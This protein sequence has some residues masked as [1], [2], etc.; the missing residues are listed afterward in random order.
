MA[1]LS[2]SL[3]ALLLF[4]HFLRRLPASRGSQSGRR[5]VAFLRLRPK[6][7]GLS[8]TLVIEWRVMEDREFIPFPQIDRREREEN[9][10]Y[11]AML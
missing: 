8:G 6:L 2:R 9:A 10:L 7:S 3:S 11:G 1:T 5:S 4:C